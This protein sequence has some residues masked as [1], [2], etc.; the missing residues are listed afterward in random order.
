MIKSTLINVAEFLGS[1]AK[2][3]M[4]NAIDDYKVRKLIR[5]SQSSDFVE[6]VLAK[7]DLRMLYPSVWAIIKEV[8]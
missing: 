4:M 2:D 7:A 6:Q 5:K 8:K 1:F 3:E